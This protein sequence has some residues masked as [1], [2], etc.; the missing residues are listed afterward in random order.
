MADKHPLHVTC[1]NELNVEKVF[2]A[3]LDTTNERFD[4][5]LKLVSVQYI[6]PVDGVHKP[7]RLV[8]IEPKHQKRARNE[9]SP[10]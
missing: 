4:R 2:Q 3:R 8:E 5:N 1:L 7:A 9:D 10:E 6:E